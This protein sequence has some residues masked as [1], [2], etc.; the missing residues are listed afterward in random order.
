MSRMGSRVR[1]P[2]APRKQIKNKYLAL[3]FTILVLFLCSYLCYTFKNSVHN[4]RPTIS[5]PCD[6]S[7]RNIHVS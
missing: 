3:I 2:Y 7:I 4:V 5:N 1:V 6:Q